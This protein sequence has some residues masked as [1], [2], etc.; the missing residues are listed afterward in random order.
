LAATAKSSEDSSVY[1]DP[2]MYQADQISRMREYSFAY[3]LD[4]YLTNA[5]SF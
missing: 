1:L 3:A 4:A 2:V 5:T